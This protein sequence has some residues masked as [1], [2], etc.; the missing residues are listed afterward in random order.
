MPTPH[1]SNRT[2][3][4]QQTKKLRN[5]VTNV[6]APHQRMPGQPLTN[7]ARPASTNARRAPGPPAH[8]PGQGQAAGTAP[9]KAERRT[10]I[11]PQLL[12][13]HRTAGLLKVG[14]ELV[15]LGPVDALLDR[16]G[17]LIDE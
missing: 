14:L 9:H 8:R 5:A 13:L 15:S 7:V 6:T 11:S 4:S 1:Q 12:Q 16:L 10:D 2:A 3:E 17:R